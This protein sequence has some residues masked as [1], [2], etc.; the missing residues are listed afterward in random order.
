MITDKDVEIEKLKDSFML[1]NKKIK[2]LMQTLDDLKIQNQ[3]LTETNE[4]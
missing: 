4:G 2:L 3:N 1:A